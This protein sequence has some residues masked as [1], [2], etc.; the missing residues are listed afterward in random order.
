MNPPDP[1]GVGDDGGGK[2]AARSDPEPTQSHPTLS[3]KRR[4]WIWTGA[5]LAAAAI[6]LIYLSSGSPAGE[7]RSP[8]V[9]EL[10]DHDVF[11][12]V[13]AEVVQIPLVDYQAVRERRPTLD[14]YID[15][16]ARTDPQALEAASRE[17]RLAF[18]INAYNA[19]MLRIVDE[20]Y[21]IERGGVG[22]FGRV[23]NLVAG[24]P[25]NSVWQIR[26]VFTRDHCPVAG[27]NRS[28]DE[29]E[30]EIIR[31]RFQEPRIHFAV[32]CAALSCP[33]LWPEAYEGERLEAQLE[34]AVEHFMDTP[35]HFR[36]EPGP[37]ATLHLN[38]VLDWY[39]EDFGGERGLKEFFAPYLEG[40]DREVV[41]REATRVRFVD[42]DWHLN[43]VPR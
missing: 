30:H 6:G 21:P 35:E 33:I 12:R 42:Y 5:L 43:D 15:M 34:R 28:Q 14:R 26:D 23:R 41:L 29:I 24:Y 4:L 13:L 19:C 36:L 25:E 17:E 11:T 9:Q 10:P 38:K 27:R 39:Q 37:P 31:P 8:V 1:V 2:D 40:V 32:N 18:W 16:L 3:R 22:L 7:T 20:H